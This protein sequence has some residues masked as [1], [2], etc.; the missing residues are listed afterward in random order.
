MIE[1]N[2]PVMITYASVGHSE[3]W[4]PKDSS[5]NRNNNNKKKKQNQEKKNEACQT[6]Y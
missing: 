3:H 2:S 4:A 5:K 1:N 6:L